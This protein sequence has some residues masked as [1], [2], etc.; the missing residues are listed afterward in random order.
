V[1]RPDRGGAPRPLLWVL[2]ALVVVGAL[3]SR[4]RAR[5][6]PAGVDPEDLAEG[7]EHSDLQP[8]VVMAGAVGLLITMAV[9]L[10]VISVFASSVTGIP[11]TIRPLAESSQ[12]LAGGPPPTPPPPRLEAQ[13][14]QALA[15][16]RDFERRKLS[17]YRWVDRQAGLV[18]IPIDRAMDVVA[19][20]GLPARPAPSDLGNRAPSVSSS[21]RVDEA[22]P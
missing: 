10:I 2:E 20:Q 13:P 3:L 19:Q 17:T 9:L 5:G 21:G 15:A 12:G 18:A 14:G 11:V 1:A 8:G 16:Y 6:L 22:Y 4:R 7:Y